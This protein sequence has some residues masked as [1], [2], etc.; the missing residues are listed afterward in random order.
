MS[1]ATRTFATIGAAAPPPEDLLPSGGTDHRGAPSGSLDHAFLDEVAAI[2][3]QL[4]PLASRGAL[5][6]S[7]GREAGHAT[8]GGSPRSSDGSGRA[9][10]ADHALTPLQVAY[11]LRWLELGRTFAAPAWADLF[12]GPVE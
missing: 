5:A 9:D 1:I 2:R 11:A 4:A 12:D 6:A 10:H 3:Q 8:L 7:F